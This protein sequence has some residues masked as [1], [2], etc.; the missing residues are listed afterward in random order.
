MSAAAVLVP[1]SLVECIV[2]VRQEL[3]IPAGTE[4]APLLTAEVVRIQVV[5]MQRL[6]KVLE[7]HLKQVMWLVVAV[8]NRFPPQQAD[9]EI[10]QQ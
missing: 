4:A 3:H 1:G 7:K 5:E 9:T 2:T 10:S 8:G 6:I